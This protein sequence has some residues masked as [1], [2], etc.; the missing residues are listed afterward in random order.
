MASQTSI[1]MGNDEFILYIRKWHPNCQ[2]STKQLGKN[3]WKWLRDRKA[4]KIKEQ[5]QHTYW[6][7]A[8]KVEIDMLPEHAT[9]FLFDRNLL[10]ELYG[11]L[12]ELG[13][14]TA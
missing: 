2:A 13:S 9:Q 14:K 6:V 11:Y 10:P 1:R 7:K 4:K 12:D 5:P 8:E 3:I